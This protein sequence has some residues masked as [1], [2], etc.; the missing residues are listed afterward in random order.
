MIRAESMP[1]DSQSS[2][3]GNI[4]GARNVMV[5]GA[6]SRT[7]DFNPLFQSDSGFFFAQYPMHESG[8]GSSVEA[9]G[10]EIQARRGFGSR[11]GEV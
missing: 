7:Q 4:H 5:G 8:R 11:C 6:G 1:D 2:L 9:L 10:G 3:S